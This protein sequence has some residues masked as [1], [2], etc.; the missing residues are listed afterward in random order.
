MNEYASLNRIKSELDIGD[1]SEDAILLE[2]LEASSR[3]VDAYCQRH[4]YSELAT[5]IYLLQTARRFFVDDLISV[6]SMKEINTISGVEST[7]DSAK[8]DLEPFTVAKYPKVAVRLKTDYWTGGNK[9]Q[10]EGKWGYKDTRDDSG[11]TVQDDPLTASATTLN[12]SKGTNFSVGQTLLIDDEQLYIE[13]I[14]TNALTVKRAVNG[15]TAVEHVKT[16]KI[17]IYSYPAQVVQ[18]CLM[19]TVRYHRGKDASH[20]DIVGGEQK[21]EFGREP[22]LPI[23]VLLNPLRRQSFVY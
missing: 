20:A 15:T 13:A 1:T 4:F 3:F 18:A 19:Q 2:R 7:I 12:V 22:A 23:R 16:T 11:D 5:R 14:A 17:Y 9:L 10:I 21:L 8:Y 6:T